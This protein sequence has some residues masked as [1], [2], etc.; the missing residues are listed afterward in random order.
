MTVSL[1]LDGTL[2]DH[3]AAERTAA[4]RFL[5]SFRRFFPILPVLVEGLCRAGARIS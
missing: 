3:D 4:G 2:L 5:G 1:D